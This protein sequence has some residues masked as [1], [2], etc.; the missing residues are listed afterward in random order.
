MGTSLGKCVRI[1]AGLFVTAAAMADV[2][3]DNGGPDATTYGTESE[4]DGLVPDYMAFDNFTLEEGS[5]VVTDLHWWGN[6]Y[7]YYAPS[8]TDNFIIYIFE[9][10]EGV[11]DF[12]SGPL[13]TID[14]SA[15]TPREDTGL[16][17]NGNTDSPVFAYDLVFDPITLDAN[18]TYWLSITND[19]YWYWQGST[20]PGTSYSIV[21]PDFPNDLEEW[22]DELETENYNLAFNLTGSVVP[23]PSTVVLL[24]A[25][26]AMLFARQR[27][28]R[29]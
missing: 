28:R 7:L 24:G 5:N 17:A 20:T 18:T 14:G 26:V 6:H 1:A 27:M 19:F 4:L 12:S 16:D 13:H 25:G 29:S 10:N 22:S 23:E 21:G 8:I 9:D 11:P 2:I 3:Y 15:T